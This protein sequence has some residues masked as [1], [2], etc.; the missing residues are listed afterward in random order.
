MPDA[1]H[2]RSSKLGYYPTNNEPSSLLVNRTRTLSSSLCRR[3]Q[4][5]SSVVSCTPLLSF[6]S[7]RAQFLLCC[8]I[9]S[10]FVALDLEFLPW[11]FV[12]SV[13]GKKVA[14]SCLILNF[15]FFSIFLGWFWDLGLQ[16]LRYKFLTTNRLGAPLAALVCTKPFFWFCYSSPSLVCKRNTLGQE[17]KRS[18]WSCSIG[19]GF[20]GELWCY[21]VLEIT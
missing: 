10:V 13:L 3:H 5:H 8:W 2:I 9:S 11:D 14:R 18:G 12:C 19:S 4:I 21:E 1:E 15:K 6:V 7:L 17:K 20:G 16:E